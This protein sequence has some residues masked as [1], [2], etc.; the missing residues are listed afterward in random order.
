MVTKKKNKKRW[1]LEDVYHANQQAM[2][3]ELSGIR[4]NIKHAPTMGGAS[5][6]RWKVFFNSILPERYNI[7]EAH[8][9]DAKGGASEQIDLVI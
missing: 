2:L 6:K 8:I 7:D 4:R 5:Q 3:G 1:S 9:I